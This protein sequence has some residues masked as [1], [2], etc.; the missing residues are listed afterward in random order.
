MKEYIDKLSLGSCDFENPII[1]TSVDCIEENI[2]ADKMVSGEFIISAEN[3]KTIKGVVYSTHEKLRIINSTFF[4]KEVAIRYEID[5]F[6][7]LENEEIVGNINIVSNGGEASVPFKINIRPICIETTIGEVKN[8][9]HFANLVQTSYDEALNL[10]KSQRFKKVLLKDDFYLESVY[11]GL[12]GSNDLN[13]AMEELL[14]AANK[15]TKVTIELNETSRTYENL[16]ENYGDF[17]VITKNNWG[18]LNIDVAVEG[19]FITGYKKKITTHDFAGSSYEFSYLIDVKRLRQG[20]NFGKIKFI[21]NSKILTFDILVKAKT[22]LTRDKLDYQKYGKQLYRLY[23]DFRLKKIDIEKWSDMSLAIIERMRAIDDTS[24]FI[25]LFQAQVEI[26]KGRESESAWILENVAESLIGKKDDNIEMYCYYLYVRTLQKRDV[27]FTAEVIKKIREYYDNG[28]DSYKLLW[29]LF[30]LDESFDTNQSLKIARIKEQY[31]KGMSSP[32]MYYEAMREFNEQPEL[33]RFL[34]DFEIQILCFG[35]KEGYISNRLAN[36]L[37]DVCSSMKRFNPLLLKILT[38]IYDTNK[39]INILS[40]IISMLIKGNIT[41]SRYFCWYEEAVARGIKLTGLYEYY[42]QSLPDDYNQPIPQIVLM[43]FSYNT[44]VSSDKLSVLYRNIIENK[45]ENKNIYEAFLKQMNYY[46]AGC[47]SKGNI[48][49]N[50]AVV[51]ED[52]LKSAMVTKEMAVKLPDIVN[53]YVVRCNNENMRYVYLL[54]KEMKE[55]E[56]YPIVDGKAYIPIYTS[57]PALIFSNQDGNRYCKTIE[58]TIDKLLDMEDYLKICNEMDID[59]LH[60]KLYFTDK[61][62]K[63]HKEDYKENTVD[64]LEYISKESSIRNSYK[65]FL[66]KEIVEYYSSNYDGDKVDE[67]LEE[68]DDSELLGTSIRKIEELMIV[69][70]IYDKAFLYMKKFGY[71]YIEPRR[72]LKF[73]NKRILDTDFANDKLLVEMAGY[74]FRKGKYNENILRYLEMYYYGSTEEMYNLWTRCKDYEIVDRQMCEKLLAQM[75]FTRSYINKATKIYKEYLKCGALGNVKKAFLFYK[76]YEYFVHDAVIDD[77]IFDFIEEELINKNSIPQLC[78][79]AYAKNCASLEKLDETQL[80][81][82]KNVVEDMC[83]NNKMFG[84]FKKFDKYFKLPA[85]IVD[86][87]IVEYH[88]SSDSKVYIH[89]QLETGNLEKKE[90][91]VSKMD[92]IFNS[93]FVKDFIL[94]YGEKIKYYITEEID[95]EVKVTESKNLVSEEDGLTAKNTRFGM[96]NDMMVCQDMKDESTLKDLTMQ[97][98]ATLELNNSIFSVM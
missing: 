27:G 91:S 75:L 98:E 4:G 64:I 24:Y 52:V 3:E 53:T 36:Q 33:L 96:L 2:Y 5:T 1:A 57:E 34:N 31:L 65:I 18:Y 72:V 67:F 59:D 38:T 44:S 69:R 58:Y 14:I 13:L 8:L 22:T 17:V 32:I 97:Y 43:Y 11:E 89:Y 49:E 62:V 92:N 37:A 68:I 56:C 6:G 90:Y 74:L 46:V 86:K 25:K 41:D 20:N 84:F 94:F 85:S 66:E 39:N 71:T 76:S 63:F 47:I 51:Y 55:C 15:K 54:H 87:T 16:S 50:L 83:R 30:Y 21:T 7:L 10:F 35:S 40:S 80:D 88:A 19:D 79:L 48:D 29:I 42:M 45:D 26:S 77:E 70:G 93:I 81:I 12:A 9:F 28:Y 73:V 95:G 23:L 60:L 78:S 82:C 61:F